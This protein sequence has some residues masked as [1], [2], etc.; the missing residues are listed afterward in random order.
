MKAHVPL[1]TLVAVCLTSCT[2]Y[3][4]RIVQPASG[5]SAVADQPVNVRCEPLDYRLF[6]DH[7]HLAMQVTNPTDDRIVLLGNSSFVIDPSG[8]SHPIRDR[9]LG[10]HSFT[11]FLLPPIPFTY[12]TPDYWGWGPGW[13]WGYTGSWYDPMW[14]PWFG[15]GWW[16]PPLVSYQQVLTVYDWRWK[17]GPARL[18][19]TYERAG[20]SIEHDFEFV[21]E[22]DKK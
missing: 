9:V 13:G 18:R 21:R 6:R 8:E 3:R 1:I 16:G 14:G 10:P 17:T 2:T 7:D 12:A 5:A 4:Y 19:L 20:K 22:P 15:S 11:M